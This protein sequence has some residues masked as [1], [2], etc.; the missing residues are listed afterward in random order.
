MIELNPLD[1]LNKRSLKWLP[2]HFTKSRFSSLASFQQEKIDTWI[3]HRLK[4]RYCVLNKPDHTNTPSLVVGFEDEK[5]LTYF[6]L[7]C[8]FLRSHK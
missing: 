5:E 4:G 1:V 6:M 7:A 3:K 8:P 2:P